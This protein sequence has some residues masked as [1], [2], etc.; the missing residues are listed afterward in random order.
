MNNNEANALWYNGKE[1]WTKP[2]LETKTLDDYT[3][4]EIDTMSKN[5]TL[6]QYFE[7]G[8]KKTV[9]INDVE[10]KVGIIHIAE[11]YSLWMF[12]SPTAYPYWKTNTTF[13]SYYSTPVADAAGYAVS[14]AK[15][16]D[17]N[18][19]Y[20]KYIY[21]K[22]RTNNTGSTT[23]TTRQN[24]WA[25]SGFNLGSGLSGSSDLNFYTPFL[26]LESEKLSTFL[27]TDETMFWTRTTTGKNSG[28]L[29]Y[30]SADYNHFSPLSGMTISNS[31]TYPILPMFCI[32]TA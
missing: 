3:W 23:S 27:D 28:V 29:M 13:T 11:K 15:S 18:I 1:I 20:N 30:W 21:I 24:G 19:P 8:D 4:A 22:Y 14:V 31:T 16:G 10:Y 6:G 12:T 25:I 5:G 2:I 7:C 9:T 17:E 26:A 32:G